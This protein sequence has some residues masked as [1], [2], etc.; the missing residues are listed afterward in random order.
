M[1]FFILCLSLFTIKAYGQA[2]EFISNKDFKVQSIVNQV[3]IPC[4]DQQSRDQQ[5][6]IDCLIVR[7]HNNLN[8]S[9]T[10]KDYSLYENLNPEFQKEFGLDPTINPPPRSKPRPLLKNSKLQIQLH[11]NDDSFTG[12]VE[13]DAVIPIDTQEDKSLFIQP[14]FILSIRNIKGQNNHETLDK[15]FIASA[16]IVYRFVYQ[17]GVL[18]LNLFYDHL[19]GLKND[20]E[21]KRLSIGADYQSGRHELSFNYYQP[22]SDWIDIHDFYQERAIASAD[23][24][25]TY[26]LNNQLEGSIGFTITDYKTKE[27]QINLV[28]GMSYKIDCDQSLDLGLEKNLDTDKTKVTLTYNMIGLLEGVKGND[29]FYQPYQTEGLLNRPVKRN[30][31]FQLEKRKKIISLRQKNLKQNLVNKNFSL[32]NEKLAPRLSAPDQTIVKGQSKT[33]SPVI[34][35][36]TPETFFVVNVNPPLKTG[37]PI[38]TY[39][40]NN[41]QFKIDA[42]EADLGESL[43]AGHIQSETGYFSYWFFKVKVI[44]E[45][46]DRQNRA[47]REDG[48][49]TEDGDNTQDREDREDPEDTQDPEDREDTQ[50]REDGEGTD[51]GETTQPE[52]NTEDGGNTE[53]DNIAPILSTEKQSLREGTTLN[54]KPVITQLRAGESFTVTISTS[55]NSQSPALSWDSTTRS[56]KIDASASQV[57]IRDHSYIGTIQDS[58]GNQNSWSLIVSVTQAPVIIN[59]PIPP[60][61]RVQDLVIP[62]PDNSDTEAPTLT[63]ENQTL[64]LGNSLSFSPTIGNLRDGE[65]F[66]VTINSLSS[67]APSVTWDQ[68]NQ[69]FNLDSSSSTARAG[70][71][72]ISGTIQDNDNNSSTWEFTV[73]V[74]AILVLNREVN[75]DTEAPTLTAENQTLKVGQSKT[76]SPTIG[77]LRENEA[78][79]VAINSLSSNAPTVTWDQSNQQFTINASSAT[80]GQYTVSGTITDGNNNSSTWE[81]TV[82]VTAQQSTPQERTVVDSQAPTL[83]TSDR[84]VEL[85]QSIIFGA[86][87]GSL[88]AGESFTVALN[89]LPNNAPTVTWTQ[90]TKKFTI[91][92]SSATVGQYTVS[93]TITDGNNNSSTWSFKVTVRD[94]QAPTLTAQSQTLEVGQS[95]TV[96]PSISSLRTGESFTVSID[97]LANNAPTVTWTQ[98]TKK[99]NISTSSAELGSYTIS[100]TITDGHSNSNR[101]SF[102]LH[103]RDTTGPSLTASNL[104]MGLGDS[105]SFSP[106]IGNLRTG[107]SFTVSIDSLLG[108]A[109]TVTWNHN[110]KKFTVT[111]SQ[112]DAVK[113]HLISGTITDGNNNSNNWSFRVVVSQRLIDR[114]APTLTAQDQSTTQ[115]TII[116]FLPT[117]RNLRTGESFTVSITSVSPSDGAPTVTW[118]HSQRRFSID[119]RG[120]AARQYTVSGTITDGHNNSSTWSFKMIVDI[121]N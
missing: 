57:R 116:Y 71:Y 41:N 121:T 58:S 31:E 5:N 85:G 4:R 33:F 27:D 80:L 68:T 77:N 46:E 60:E 107:E 97:S 56:F 37:Q 108:T 110:T 105:L 26:L 47:G 114:I 34:G 94:S 13:F 43:I 14:G 11:A 83:T 104:A 102:R 120:S 106:T 51:P 18:G 49:R 44:S 40:Q 15:F 73:N 59:P 69:Q 17:D 88:R 90:S 45:S 8:L 93:G 101:W 2:P 75:L 112:T 21:H 113:T 98:S 16:G 100:G 23:L 35:N 63:A 111:V 64:S 29:C 12:R 3:M 78:F 92:A 99:F 95:K 30:K 7:S 42:K 6:M 50:P 24:T 109:P 66:T 65:S 81:F 118:Q 79:T 20:S 1:R 62:A 10:H 32:D 38:V 84:V 22:L 91:D 61:S 115:E 53:S 28:L 19:W 70:L 52:D 36:I 48:D 72:T 9:A 55:P 54:Y 76:F 74:T 96:S 39:S 89:A 25:W 87:I 82:T 117:I 119:S 86:T 103:V 67:P